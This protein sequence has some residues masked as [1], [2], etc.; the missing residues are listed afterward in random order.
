V[1][2]LAGLQ[3]RLRSG[4]RLTD[5]VL[6]A[7]CDTLRRHQAAS[8][9]EC[10]PGLAP[11][12]RAKSLLRAFTRDVSRALAD[13]SAEQ[14]KDNWDLAIFGHPGSLSFT[15]ITQPWLAAAA[16]QWAAGAAAG[17]GSG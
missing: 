2:V 12:K 3:T 10:D 5:V 14:R 9:C 7:V 1:E 6:R 8:I 13:P 4:L 16:M 11:G 17:P 15:M